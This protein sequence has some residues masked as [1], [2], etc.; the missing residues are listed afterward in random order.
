MT[1][2]HSASCCPSLDSNKKITKVCWHPY[3]AKN[4]RG[5]RLNQIRKTKMFPQTWK[6]DSRNIHWINRFVIS[7]AFRHDQRTKGNDDDR[8]LTSQD[9]LTFNTVPS[10]WQYP[11]LTILEPRY[12]QPIR[13]KP[14]AREL[15]AIRWPYALRL[16]YIYIFWYSWIFAI[17]IYIYIRNVLQR[18]P[19]SRHS[20]AA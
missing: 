14:Y 5:K 3:G 13:T 7:C 2:F 8:L 11:K 18:L 16:T 12:F 19:A 17:C 6:S 4:T 15:C 1:L 9:P 20:L 10:W